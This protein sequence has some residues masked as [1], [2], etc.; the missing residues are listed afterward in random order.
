MDLHI[1]ELIKDKLKEQQISVIKF[2]SLINTTRENV[3][4]IFKRK[5]IDTDML[6]KISITLKY[7]F[8]L[9]I[10]D[11]TN[12]YLNIPNNYFNSSNNTEVLIKEFDFITRENAL[13]KELIRLLKDKYE[14]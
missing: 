1:G 12:N 5:S 8:F 3:Y 9:D 14:K 2:A 7:N 4:G 13:L 6:I 11:T 10:S